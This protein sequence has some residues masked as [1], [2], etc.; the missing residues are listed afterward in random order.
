MLPGMVAGLVPFLIG[1]YDPWRHSGGNYGMLPIV[2]GLLILLRCVWDFYSSG[3]GTLA[4]WS[5]PKRLINN[6]LYR[7]TR[8]P[9][10][11]GVALVL[12]GES[13]LFASWLLAGYGLV[14]MLAFNMHIRFVEEPWLKRQWPGEWKE[15]SERVPRWGV[16]LGDGSKKTEDQ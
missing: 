16:R 3:H 10:Y 1:S 8:N 13:L 12:L 2:L 5:P 4:H 9:M 15:F 6:G 11:T 7:Y 14:V